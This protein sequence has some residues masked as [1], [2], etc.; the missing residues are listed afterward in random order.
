ME[1]ST[2]PARGQR[3]LVLGFDAGCMKCSEMAGRIEEAVG[4]RLEVKSLRDP[5][6]EHWRKQAL[7]EDAPWAPT[8][9]EVGGGEVRAWT[10][11]RMGARMS[12]I[13]GPLATWRVMQVIGE[14]G[15][16]EKAG[17]A[18]RA[19]DVKSPARA[20]AG[21]TRAQVLKGGLAGAVAGASILLGT[22]RFV[23]SAAAAQSAQQ[24]YYPP[25]STGT[26]AQQN[27]AK[28]IVRSSGPYEK[29][30]ADQAEA[31]GVSRDA[32]GAS[33]DLDRAIVNVEGQYAG[34]A[35]VSP[36]PK[37]G[38]A[39]AFVVD[40]SG[41]SVG[42]VRTVEA[43]PVDGGR[44]VSVVTQE[45][46]RDIKRFA[47]VVYTRDYMIAEGRKIS[48]GEARE[49]LNR[50]GA[51]QTRGAAPVQTRRSC[52]DYVYAIASALV[53]GYFCTFVCAIVAAGSALI[54][55]IPCFT[56]CTIVQ[57]TGA[58]AAQKCICEN[59]PEYCPCDRCT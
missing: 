1:E 47:R 54:G 59:R 27:K 13:L 37:R 2:F 36:D 11:L 15:S 33:F 7:G 57:T 21:L 49:E 45:N 42:N 44:A 32:S 16:K 20:S 34:V 43:A 12:R 56:A 3:R 41:G 26:P 17:E 22:D 5:Q 55:G 9:V 35:V 50:L 48:Y 40:L 6:V 4:D 29:L 39:A 31:L 8:L 19:L 24:G 28:A 18:G 58:Y 25:R 23:P 38:V 52:N 10:G 14:P 46:F 30:V 53:G 51:A